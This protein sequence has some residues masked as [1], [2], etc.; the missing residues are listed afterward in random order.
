MDIRRTFLWVIF[1]FSLIMLWDKWNVYSGRSSFMNPTPVKQAPAANGAAANGAGTPAS[2][3]TNAGSAGMPGAEAAPVKGET[4]EISTDMVKAQFDTKGAVLTRLE[5]L[6]HKEAPKQEWYDPFLQL[7][8]AKGKPADAGNVVIFDNV[9][10]HTYL[11]RTGLDNGDFPNSDSLYT[12]APGPRTLEGDAL[13]LVFTAE[14]G[15]VK[16]TKTFTFHKGSYIIDTTH[17]VTNAGA[18]TVSP[19]LY[20]EL[21]RD[22]NKPDAPRFAPSSFIGPALYSEEGHYQ[23]IEFSDIEKKKK[24]DY[25]A[26]ADNGWIAMVQHYFVSSLILDPKVARENYVGEA[27]KNLYRVG[28]KIS[29][30]TLAAGATSTTKAVLYSGPQESQILDKLAPGMEK[31][32]DFG[33]L[34]IFAEPIFAVM[35]FLHGLIG[36][37]GWTIIGFTVLIKLLFFPLSAASY[38]SMARMKV[39]TPKMQALR[40]RFKDDPAKMNQAMME[41]YRTEKVNPLGGCWPVLIQMPVFLALYWVLMATVETRNAPWLGW[42]QDLASPDPFFILPLIMAISMFVQTKLNPPPPDPMQAKMMM[43]M[44]LMFSVMFFFFPSGLV[45]YYVVNNLLSIAQQYVIT[46]KLAPSN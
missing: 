29:L 8:G 5:L 27:G 39:L 25:V 7:V 11:G 1:T 14:K 30:G 23:K 20:M 34:A 41:L 40:E 33:R 13:Q 38:R 16:L 9:P 12:L 24:L 2:G 21:V 10:G 31:V 22:G 32:K 37:W 35:N 45:L 43:I 19:V 6:K 36:N 28:T 46:K 4:I 17:T 18:A 26:K 15:G 42:I 3:T 44:P